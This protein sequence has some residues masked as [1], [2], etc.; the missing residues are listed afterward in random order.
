MSE[1]AYT[2][3]IWDVVWFAEKNIFPFFYFLKKYMKLECFA[4]EIQTEFNSVYSVSARADCSLYRQ[5][6]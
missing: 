3:V 4:T 5:L 2:T 1:T 6:F